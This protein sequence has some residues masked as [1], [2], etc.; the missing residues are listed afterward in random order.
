[1]PDS[2]LTSRLIYHSSFWPSFY[3]TTLGLS[4]RATGRHNIPTTGPALLVA[5]HQSFIDPWLIGQAAT[6][7]LR[8]LARH[9][10]FNNKYFASLIRC[11]GAVPIDR[12]F[13][14]EGLQTVFKELEAGQAVVIFA[15]GER[16]HTGEVQPL[17]PGISLLIKRVTCP[18]IPV[19][20]AGAYQMW[21]R[22]QKLPRPECLFL[23]ATGRAIT[24]AYG[25]PIDSSRYKK[26]DRDAMLTDLRDAIVR[27]CDTANRLRRKPNHGT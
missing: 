9:T 21:P 27:S 1:M 4:L 25:E 2:E 22:H 26:M 15:E 10:L 3:A 23:P 19:G 6:R 20:L 12:G 7:R 13:G 17:K 16:T 18:I 5:N 8:Y 11:Y 14:K 24:V